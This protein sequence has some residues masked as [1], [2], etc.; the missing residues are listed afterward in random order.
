MAANM[1]LAINAAP[2]NSAAK[3]N[4]MTP[5]TTGP[6]DP[7]ANSR[8]SDAGAAAGGN[9]NDNGNDGGVGG[10]RSLVR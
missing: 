9:G 4:E 10:S 6:A 2:A 8:Q 3:A 7:S 1:K 5:R